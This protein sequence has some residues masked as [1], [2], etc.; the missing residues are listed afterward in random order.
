MDMDRLTREIIEQYP[1]MQ[2]PEADVQIEGALPRV[3]A[4]EATLTQ[5][6]SN[7]LGNAIKFVVPGE[8]PHVRIRAERSKEFVRIWFEDKGIGIAARDQERIF[9]IFV[10]VHPTQTYNGTGIGLSIVRRAAEKMGGKIGV[11]SE[12]GSG[13]RF[14]LELRAVD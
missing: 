11:E 8:K 6:V 2:S 14:W 3:W 10:K 9:G 12:L 7:L 5:C 1:G 13:S 4:N